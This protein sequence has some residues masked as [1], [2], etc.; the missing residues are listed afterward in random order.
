MAVRDYKMRTLIP[1]SFVS[2]P[3]SV[4]SSKMNNHPNLSSTL[5]RRVNCVAQVFLSVQ[6]SLHPVS[7]EFHQIL[8]SYLYCNM[9]LFNLG[10]FHGLS[11]TSAQ[12]RCLNF[13]IVFKE[14]L[15]A[16]F[17][18]RKT[19]ST[20]PQ[21]LWSGAHRKRTQSVSFSS[22]SYHFYSRF[23]CILK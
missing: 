10:L 22:K 2:H 6:T 18:P 5:K 16:L 14:W 4:T 9:L 19:D 11:W 13:A 23:G 1:I 21:W 17:F 15:M 7:S 3:H 8:L 12:L 20:H